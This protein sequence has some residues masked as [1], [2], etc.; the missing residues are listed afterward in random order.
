MPFDIIEGFPSLRFSKI[1]YPVWNFAERRR[2]LRL[3]FG[4][5]HAPTAT[6]VFNPIKEALVADMD[7]DD[8]FVKRIAGDPRPVFM[9]ALK[10]LRQMRLQT[11]TSRIQ[12][13]TAVIPF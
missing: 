13:I 6:A 1:L 4:E 9:G 10:Q 7:T 12:T 3:N 5:T 11:E 8:H 2:P